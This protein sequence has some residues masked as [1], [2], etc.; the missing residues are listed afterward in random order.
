MEFWGFPW[1]LRSRP[2]LQDAPAEA[3]PAGGMPAAS[4]AKQKAVRRRSFALLMT[5]AQCFSPK[6]MPMLRAMLTIWSSWGTSF[7]T[8]AISFSGLCVIWL[9]FSATVTP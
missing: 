4:Q 9:P 8:P 2:P 7:G 3:L 1:T 6:E 5:E